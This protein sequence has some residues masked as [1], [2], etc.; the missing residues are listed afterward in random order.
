[1]TTTGWLVALDPGGR[2][3]TSSEFAHQLSRWLE[4]GKAEI[5][6]VIGGADGIPKALLERADSKLALSRMT[7]PH[8]LA[9][10]LLFEQLYRAFAILK[11]EPYARED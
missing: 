10:V 5:D 4:L 9:R 2:E 11:N 6:F 7:L 1:V 3:L 8:R